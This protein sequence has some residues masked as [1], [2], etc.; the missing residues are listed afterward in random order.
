MSDEKFNQELLSFIQHSPTPFHAVHSMAEMLR[1]GGFEELD[2]AKS[3]SLQ[4]GSSYFVIRNGSALVAFRYGN[5]SLLDNGLR[6]SGAHTDS[7]CLKIKPNPEINKHNFLQLGVEIYGGALLYPWFD[8]DLSMAGR[9]DF[10]TDNGELSS[11]LVDFRDPIAFIPSLAIHLDRNANDGRKIDKHKELPPILAQL[12]IDEQFSFDDF[13]LRHIEGFCEVENAAKVLSYDLSLYD[14]QSPSFVGIKKQFMA[15]ARLDNLLSC[16]IACK[17]LLVCEN[18]HCSMLVCND[19]EEV[20]SASSSG[21]QGPFLKSVLERLIS[22]EDESRDAFERVMR[23][24]LLF[25]ID[26]AHGV[27][28]NFSEKHD[29]KHMP[30]LNG[31]PVIK[32]NANQRYAS[33]SESIALVKSLCKKLRLPYQSFAMRTGM[34]C[35]S[36]IG[37]ITAAE[38][39]ITTLDIGVASFGMHSIREIVGSA[40]SITINSIVTAYFNR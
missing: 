19:H 2:E 27:H 40:D 23:Q 30:L 15:S 1:R 4:R 25:S 17:S 13:L 11:C 18:L 28:P 12:E 14:S 8:R 7:P 10:E 39:G 34:A 32:V 5:K 31:G 6:I 24:S 37:P 21:A 26:N 22:S 16:F 29:D 9:V 35:G 33:N 3:W 38:L 36:T 20:G